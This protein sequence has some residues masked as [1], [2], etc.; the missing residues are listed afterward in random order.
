MCVEGGGCGGGDIGLRKVMVRSVNYLEVERMCVTRNVGLR[1]VMVRSVKYFKV[2]RMCVT[3]N[4][5]VLK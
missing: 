2:E 4:Q 5:S 1:K 3:S